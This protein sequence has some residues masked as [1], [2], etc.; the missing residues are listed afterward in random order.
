[1]TDFKI[2]DEVLVKAT[3]RNVY[4]DD[5]CLL[6]FRDQKNPPTYD[7][8]FEAELVKNAENTLT[9]EK[10]EMFP[11]SVA[12]DVNKGLL[13]ALKPFAERAAAYD[14][15]DGDDD[16]YAWFT[17]RYIKIRDLRRARDAIAAAEKGGE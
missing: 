12:L 16:D 14:P 8:S 13:E 15:E 2:G 5:W 10:P 7:N 9:V 1:M 6:Q 3:V 17:G 4:D 11:A